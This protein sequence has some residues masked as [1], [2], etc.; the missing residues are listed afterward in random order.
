MATPPPPPRMAGGAL[1]AAG[2]LG[3]VVIGSAAGQPS[4]GFLLGLA[5]GLAGIIAVWLVDRRRR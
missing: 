3:G 4:L 1:L 5:V 2:I